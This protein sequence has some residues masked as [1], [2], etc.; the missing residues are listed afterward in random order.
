MGML[1]K[2]KR[3]FPMASVWQV[4]DNRLEMIASESIDLVFSTLTIAHVEDIA[5]LIAS[6]ART[7]KPGGNLIIT[8][9]HPELLEAGGTRDF[10]LKGKKYVIKNHVHSLA[11]VEEVARDLG[12]SLLTRMERRI[13][14]DLKGFFIKQNALSVY[15]KFEGNHVI[16]AM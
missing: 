14:E 16:Y 9:Y 3:K 1:E 13:D 12:F 6:F 2:L 8:D 5:E 15:N 11:R 4:S 10:S 7:T